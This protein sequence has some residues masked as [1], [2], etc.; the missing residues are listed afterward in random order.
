MI[1]K[2]PGSDHA[3]EAYLKKGDIVFRIEKRPASGARDLSGGPLQG[4]VPAGAFAQRLGRIYLVARRLRERGRVLHEARQRPRAGAPRH[5]G[6]LRRPSPR[7]PGTVRSGARHAHVSR[8][9]ESVVADDERRDT[10][11]PG[12][13]RRGFRGT[14]RTSPGISRRSGARSPRTRRARSTRCGPSSRNPRTRRFG[15]GRSSGPA[16]S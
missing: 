10:I 8:R 6:L 16:S 1:A 9:R 4:P 5:G 11:S 12:R 15:R 13:S 14:R 7:D 2:F 3:E